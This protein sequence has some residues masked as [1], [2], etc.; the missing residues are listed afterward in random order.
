MKTTWDIINPVTN[1]LLQSGNSL[2]DIDAVESFS[3]NLAVEVYKSFYTS[4]Q[5]H[6]VVVFALRKFTEKFREL[7]EVKDK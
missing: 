5:Q 6:T 2:A 1:P 4:Q 3:E 7:T